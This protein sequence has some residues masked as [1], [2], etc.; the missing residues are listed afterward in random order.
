M[1]KV[2]FR[3][4]VLRARE[5]AI[6]SS[7]N[8]LLAEKGFDLMTVDEVAADAGIANARRHRHFTSKEALAAAAGLREGRHRAE[9]VAKLEIW[10]RAWASWVSAAFLGGYLERAQGSRIL[11]RN[12]ADIALLLEFFLLEKCVYEIGYELNNRPPWVDIPMR[13]LVELLP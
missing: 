12:D 5:D 6:V 9:D 4:Q 7:V 10:G 1:A 2:S 3:E 11:P 8:R 13:G